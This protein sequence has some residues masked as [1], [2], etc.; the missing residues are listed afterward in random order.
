MALRL[1]ER[2]AL[3]QGEIAEALGVSRADT[4]EV[5]AYGQS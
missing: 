1:S 3:D 4:E 2:L 5:D